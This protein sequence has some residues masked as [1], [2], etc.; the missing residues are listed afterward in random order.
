MT[1]RRAL[2]GILASSALVATSMAV[3]P[4]AVS[5]VG[6]VTRGCGV[7]YRAAANGSGGD[8]RLTDATSESALERPLAGMLVHAAAAADVNADGWPDL[9]IGTFADRDVDDYQVRGANGPAPDRLL[10]GSADGFEVDDSFPGERARTSGAAFADLDADGRPDL[11]VARNVDDADRG[12]APTEILRNVDGAFERAATLDELEGARSVGVL[13]YDLDGRLDLFVTEDRWRGRSSILYRNLGNFRFENVTAD[14]GIPDDV[15]GLGVATTDLNGDGAPD[16]FVG[17][18]NR[19]FVNDG[20]GA[21]LEA[22]GPVFRWK[23]FGDEDDPAGVAAGDVN[24]DGRP[25]LVIGQHYGSTTDGDRLVPVRLYINTGNDADGVPE[26]RDATDEAGLTGLPTKAPHVEIVDLDSDGWPDILTTASVDA[27]TPVVFRN[28]GRA[29]D[30]P[31]FEINAEPGP[32]QYWPTGVVVDADRDG[33]LDVFLAE[34]DAAKPS[35]LLLNESDAGHWLGIE[36]SAGARVTTYRAGAGGNQAAM[37]GDVTVAGAAGFGSGPPL[38]A[39]FGLGAV[40]RVDVRIRQPGARTTTLR[41]QEGD[42]MV[43]PDC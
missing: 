8:I 20:A 33:R 32:A 19:L 7:V 2:G 13:D 39:W 34:F 28:R 31:A 10:L 36:T 1:R 37:L 29:G 11:V 25:D 15:D 41:A 24:R 3:I 35:L 40:T 42:R 4:S 9:F 26:F 14:A 5:S 38:V 27:E 23:T 12:R 17:G 16:I 30:T 21:F 22:K 18:S 43:G 6:A